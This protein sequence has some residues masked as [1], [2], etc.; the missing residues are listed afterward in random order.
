MSKYAF[1]VDYPK[2]SLRYF[3]AFDKLPSLDSIE[4]GDVYKCEIDRLKFVG[5]LWLGSDFLPF[6]YSSSFFECPD[7]LIDDVATFL[8]ESFACLSRLRGI[9]RID[10]KIFK[11]EEKPGLSFV[12]SI[13]EVS[14]I[15][16]SINLD[17]CLDDI[18]F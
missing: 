14:S 10:A 11:L 9:V 12:N 18:P 5:S 15:A 3:C 4:S 8:V 6:Y 17:A 1:A 16:L 13:V 2:G 7:H